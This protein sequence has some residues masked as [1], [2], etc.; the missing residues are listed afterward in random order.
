MRNSLTSKE[1]NKDQKI[2]NFDILQDKIHYI[3][4]FFLSFNLSYTLLK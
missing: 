1:P 4:V 3:R 2:T